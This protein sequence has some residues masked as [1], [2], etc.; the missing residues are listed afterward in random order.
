MSLPIITA[1][2]GIWEASLVA[3]LERAR[4][5]VHVV[6]RCA[7][8]A[9][10][11][12]VALAG[13]ASAAVVSSDLHRLDREALAQLHHAGVAV[14][15]LAD[16]LDPDAGRRLND[17][18]IG[19]V[20]PVDASAA[21]VATALSDAV[22]VLARHGPRRSPGPATSAAHGR[23]PSGPL[24]YARCADPADALSGIAWPSP[25]GR[26]LEGMTSGIAVRSERGRIVAVWGPTGAP[27]R[28][29]VA[30]TLAG[31]FSALG[32][33]ALIVDADTYGPSVA[34][35]LGLLDE[36]GGIAG[37]VRSA[38]QGAL[39]VERLARLTPALSPTLRV[40]TGLPQPARWPEL[41]P[42]G[43]DVLWQKVRDLAR[44]TVVDCGFGLEV[45]EE[46]TFDT[47]APRRNG[48]TLSV[49]AAADVVLA[50]GC[51]DPVGLQRL[52]RGLTELADV[53]G[54]S[55]R[56][57]VVVT[58]V[59]PEAVGPDPMRR[60]SDALARYAGVDAA[61]LIPDDR[62]G[63]DHAMLTGRMLV[64]VV[65]GSPARHPLTELARELEDA[66]TAE[67]TGAR[68]CT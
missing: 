19:H 42:S 49:L 25:P 41:R 46:I 52:V 8:L 54:P 60:I 47:A 27:G 9:E 36:S 57:R 55:L 50:V 67:Q 23:S 53:M 28:T 2:T 21:D 39:D 17:L 31:E 59:R 43:L 10:L 5:E 20:L 18:G 12:S 62:V 7:D 22:H 4:G 37:A 29:T 3:G 6:R 11:L 33:Q 66:L 51:A 63:C 26:P 1:V 13:L 38:N 45:D 44:W 48:A 14:V 65:P 56:P 34:Q 64:E 40:L 16:P 68:S 35:V 30:I 24:D 15:G 61:L 58:R 32:A